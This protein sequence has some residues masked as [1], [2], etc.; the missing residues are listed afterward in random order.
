MSRTGWGAQ[1]AGERSPARCVSILGLPE[2]DQ[3]DGDAEAG[4]ART[5][6]EDLPGHVEE[7]MLHRRGGPVTKGLERI[8]SPPPPTTCRGRSRSRSSP[9]NWSGPLARSRV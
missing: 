7:Q 8:T 3:F 1:R 5:P 2:L 4:K 6:L 9:A